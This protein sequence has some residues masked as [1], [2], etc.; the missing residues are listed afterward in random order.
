MSLSR[1]R[2]PAKP[3]ATPAAAD[4]QP[5]PAT[6]PAISAVPRERDKGPTHTATPPQTPSDIPEELIAARAY[7]I[8]QQ[9]G[10]PMGQDS[11]EDWHAARTQLEQERL[12]WA[13]PSESDKQRG[14]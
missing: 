4:I 1:K 14:I 6:T 12:N 13:A 2:A 8:W 5:V 11:A 3:K 10:C 7:E 9:R